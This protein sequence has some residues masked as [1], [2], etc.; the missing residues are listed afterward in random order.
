MTLPAAAMLMR[1]VDEQNSVEDGRARA[2]DRSCND[3]VTCSFVGGGAIDGGERVDGGGGDIDWV[4]IIDGNGGDEAG[5][6]ESVA[7]CE[8]TAW[9]G[10]LGAQSGAA[11][12]S[13]V[14]IRC[15]PGGQRVAATGSLALDDVPLAP[16]RP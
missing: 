3:A 14:S 16:G 7:G 2:S 15:S 4:E 1:H 11:L 13:P 12:C 5:R 6:V 8:T 10:S 9:A